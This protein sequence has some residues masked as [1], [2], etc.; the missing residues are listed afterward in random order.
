M[1]NLT[2]EAVATENEATQHQLDPFAAGLDQQPPQAEA[3]DETD[4]EFD[5]GWEL[6]RE[7]IH[8][9]AGP[10]GLAIADQLTAEGPNKLKAG[11]AGLANIALNL[12]PE[13]AGA[14]HE[15]ESLTYDGAREY[16]LEQ[17]A[18]DLLDKQAE[19]I[20][21]LAEQIDQDALT[22]TRNVCSALIQAIAEDQQE[23]I[24]RLKNINCPPLNGS[25]AA[26]TDPEP[27]QG[28]TE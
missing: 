22:G 4:S 10:A 8:K 2:E 26:P 9:L 14:D 15:D 23:F 24:K 18:F 27:K 17:L 19:S 28:D 13:A 6:I 11:L 25:N 20:Q 1:S 5:Q 12:R 16:Q 3:E 7:G 21:Y